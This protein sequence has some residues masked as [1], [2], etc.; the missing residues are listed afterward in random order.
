MIASFKCVSRN[1]TKTEYEKKKQNMILREHVQ[2]V[3]YVS[4]VLRDISIRD[5]INRVYM[6]IIAVMQQTISK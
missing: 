3:E 4:P 6:D 1:K 2:P 5:F